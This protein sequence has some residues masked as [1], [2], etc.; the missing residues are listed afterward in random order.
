MENLREVL[1][2]IC[3]IGKIF[4]I[5]LPVYYEDSTIENF[6]NQLSGLLSKIKE[7]KGKIQ[8]AYDM[9]V[10]IKY[11]PS[12]IDE[13]IKKDA[14]VGEEIKSIDTSIDSL[15]RNIN[16]IDFREEIKNIGNYLNQR[17]EECCLLRKKLGKTKAVIR[18]VIAE[19][20][21]DI[22]AKV[23]CKQIDDVLVKADE[24]AQAL[25][26]TY[27]TLNEIEK[28]LPVREIKGRGASAFSSVSALINAFSSY[29]L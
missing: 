5:Y 17:K 8:A 29:F 2:E 16:K 19:S 11:S 22:Y 14:L 27:I 10:F 6:E 15:L 18:N 21:D 24:W 4:H 25:S 20:D 1:D 12:V 13:E 23:L 7:E 3:D 9:H 26:R 28:K